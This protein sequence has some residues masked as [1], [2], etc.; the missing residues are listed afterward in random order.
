[1][2]RW[3]IPFAGF[4]LALMGGF[5][6]AWGVFIIPMEEQFGWTK[7]EAAMPF[8]VFMVVFSLFM[9][10]AGSLQ[11]K[12]GPRKVSEIGAILFFLSYGTASL[13]DR[14]PYPL[15]LIVT[16]GIIGGIACGLTYA[17]VAPPSRKWFPDK[18]GLAIS[19]SVMG[20]GLAALVLAPLK[21]NYLIPVHGIE[22]TF[23]FIA[24]ITTL[25]S[26]LAAWLT[27]NPPVDWA[28][29]GW[30]PEAKTTNAIEINREIS[31]RQVVKSPIFWF[32]WF[33]FALVVAGGLIC[34]GL[35]PS[36][37]KLIVGMTAGKAA[38]AMSIFA[39]FNGLGRPLAG[40]LSDRFGAVWVM[41]F[42]YVVQAAIF[43][44][45]PVFAVTQTTLY[46]S[47]A[48][49]GWGYA[50]TLA[51]FPFLTSI[52]FGTRNLGV[53]YGIVFSAFGVG[54]LAP[55]IGSWIFD[56]TK[57]FT[58]IFILSG[59]MTGLGLLLCVVLKKKFTLS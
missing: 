18:P 6:Y 55:T 32:L 24:V 45:F 51:V 12:I 14:F 36:Y 27:K 38:I 42:T 19:L 47:A 22:G 4:L 5:S 30:N 41:I 8:T 31:P 10:P 50:V 16:Y 15:W 29:P 59:G 39:A 37:G 20:F 52:C 2:R 35:I 26:L 33:T 23:L 21:A 34:I 58:P 28:P 7:A 17:C 13:V 53:N 48:L 49:L 3:R 57:S 56:V 44:L 9:I 46:I 40:F 43:I 25:V 54:A 11:D 1:M